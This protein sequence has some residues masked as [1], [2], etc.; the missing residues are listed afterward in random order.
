MSMKRAAIRRGSW[1]AL[2]A[3]VV[4][5]AVLIAGCGAGSG[6]SEATAKESASS[7]SAPSQRIVK[8]SDPVT[9]S[10]GVTEIQ[11]A[12]FPNGQDTDEVSVSGTKPVKP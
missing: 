2:L 1:L 6:P 4:S 8:S 7:A 3:A 12:E 5:A 10:E 9:K 11:S